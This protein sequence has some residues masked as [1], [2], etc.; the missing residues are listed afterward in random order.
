MISVMDVRLRRGTPADADAVAEMYI[1][2]R[3]AAT[4]IPPPV[5]TDVEIRRWIADRVVSHSE[6]WIAENHTSA[7]V[8]LVV[9]DEHWLDQLYVEPTL[10]RRGIGA[11]LLSLAKQERPD[12]LRLWTFAANV[13]AQRFYERHG[14]VEADRTD[15]DNE[16]QAPD[17]LYIWHGLQRR[18]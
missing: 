13:G 1:R 3:H 7:L 14:F 5:H 10:T 4:D 18:A 15:G 11:Q 17:I 2:A 6:L 12:G 9:L 8:G 16:E